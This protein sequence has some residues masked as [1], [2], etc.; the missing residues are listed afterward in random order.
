MRKTY[1]SENAVLD[2]IPDS[3]MKHEY[4]CNNNITDL[5]FIP[6]HQLKDDKK[7]NLKQ[8]LGVEQAQIDR[9]CIKENDGF[10]VAY[11]TN[12]STGSSWNTFIIYNSNSTSGGSEIIWD[13]TK[14]ITDYGAIRQLISNKDWRKYYANYFSI[15]FSQGTKSIFNG[16]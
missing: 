12:I 5:Y 15:L 11:W 6:R 4:F 2:S 3:I 8:Y 14:K 1:L 7:A 9:Y 10:F 13:K 16:K